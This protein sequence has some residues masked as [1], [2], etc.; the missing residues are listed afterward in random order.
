MQKLSLLGIVLF[1][2]LFVS[3][4][5]PAETESS[6]TGTA[7]EIPVDPS[8]TPPASSNPPF[9]IADSSKIVTTPSGLKYYIVQQGSGNKAQPGQKVVAMYHGLLADGT[10]FDSSYDRGQPFE[11]TL[12]QGQVIR[13]WDEGF[14]IFPVGTRAVLIVPPDLGYGDRESGAIPPNSTLYFHVELLNILNK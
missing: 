12:G 8:Y 11:F 3:C 7:A 13:G 10:K 4:N 14:S 9:T 2:I 6:E 1:T 5:K